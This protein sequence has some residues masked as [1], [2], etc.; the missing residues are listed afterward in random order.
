M[1]L[2]SITAQQ[3]SAQASNGK[4]T[5]VGLASSASTQHSSA[6]PPNQTSRRFDACASDA[7]AN[8]TC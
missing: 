7:C 6:E 3:T 2:A 1:S 4:A 5:A 8:A